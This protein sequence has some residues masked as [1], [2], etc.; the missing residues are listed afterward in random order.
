MVEFIFLSLFYDLDFDFIVYTPDPEYHI[1]SSIP[2]CR[3]P[4][5]L[6]V[7]KHECF[8]ARVEVSIFSD[9]EVTLSFLDGR[10]VNLTGVNK[11]V[12]TTVLPGRLPLSGYTSQ[13]IDGHCIST[14]K[15]VETFL[16]EA[17][18]I[19]HYENEQS[20]FVLFNITVI[21]GYVHIRVKVW[22]VVL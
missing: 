15:P 11:Y 1:S 21:S 22:G 2:L 18:R 19:H 16:E 17:W 8:F 13:C 9:G 4:A 5:I 6:T 14:D 3:S 10:V 20:A 12:L 7:L